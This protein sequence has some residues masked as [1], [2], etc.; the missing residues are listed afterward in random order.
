MKLITFYFVV[1]LFFILFNIWSK[2]TEL[3]DNDF[4]NCVITF[5]FIA[6]QIVVPILFYK[7]LYPLSVMLYLRKEY[8]VS[9]KYKEA[10]TL[11]EVTQKYKLN[12]LLQYNEYDRKEA[13]FNFANSI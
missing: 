3:F 5:C 10:K 7:L 13:L 12:F 2:L 9:L 4:I 11:K 1:S 6:I 8:N